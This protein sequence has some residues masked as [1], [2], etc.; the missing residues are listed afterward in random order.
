MIVCSGRLKNQ[1]P[2][3]AKNAKI[4][5]KERKVLIAIG[6]NLSLL[7]LRPLRFYFASFAVEKAF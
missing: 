6:I 1:N 7:A 4:L 2:L 5:R 3:T